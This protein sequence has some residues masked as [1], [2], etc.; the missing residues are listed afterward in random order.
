VPEDSLKG[1]LAEIHSAMRGSLLVIWDDVSRYLLSI[2]IYLY[3]HYTIYAIAYIQNIDIYIY[4]Y[5]Y[6]YIHIYIYIY[7][8]IYNRHIISQ[9]SRMWYPL[10]KVRAT[11]HFGI[12]DTVIW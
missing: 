7:Y 6:I 2:Y 3:I 9:A 5:I 1:V 11:G 4:T 8:I 10:N 12:A